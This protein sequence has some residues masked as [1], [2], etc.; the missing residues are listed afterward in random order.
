MSIFASETTATV[1][2]PFDAPHT[3]TLQKLTG[4]PSSGAGGAPQRDRRGPTPRGWEAQFKKLLGKRLATDADVAQGAGDPLAGYDR[5]TI[6]AR[7][8]QGVE[9]HRHATRAEKP[10]PVDVSRSRRR[11]DG[12]HRDEIMKLTKPALFQTPEEREAARK[13]G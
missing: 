8:A 13:N 5:Q 1:A 7:R 3:V 6:V 4:A 9:L 2:L 10:R 12:V 11:V